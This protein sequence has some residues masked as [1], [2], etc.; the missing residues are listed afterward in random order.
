[1]LAYANL[2]LRKLFGALLLALVLA[3]CA[4]APRIETADEAAVY[5]LIEIKNLKLQAKALYDDFLLIDY[6]AMAIEQKLDQAID[7]V[8]AGELLLAEDLYSDVKSE[9]APYLDDDQNG[10]LLP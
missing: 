3:S 2:H 4:Q 9:L 6:E 10:L 5:A 8:E 7:Y 1:M